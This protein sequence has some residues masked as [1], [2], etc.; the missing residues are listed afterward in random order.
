[1]PGK[2]GHTRALTRA[3]GLGESLPFQNH[4]PCSLSH[5]PGLPLALDVMGSRQRPSSVPRSLIFV[6]PRPVALPSS[7]KENT[8]R[9]RSPTRGLAL[10]EE[11][12]KRH[13]PRV[14]RARWL[15]CNSSSGE[16]PQP[17]PPS[18]GDSRTSY[19]QFLSL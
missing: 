3:S 5:E 8:R 12:D 18:L 6:A 11:P 2:A 15:S 19:L 7:R 17:S 16:A 1:M 9:S 4:F 13:G 14:V 10:L